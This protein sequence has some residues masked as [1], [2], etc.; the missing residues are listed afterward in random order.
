MVT[1]IY[2]RQYQ[3]YLTDGCW[4]PVRPSVFFITKMDGTLD[5]WDIIFKQNDPT[6]SLQVKHI[7][8]F[9]DLAYFFNIFHLSLLFIIISGKI[10]QL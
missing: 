7:N 6:L 5:V 9:Y 8:R 10:N 1:I 4:S 3:S 2:C